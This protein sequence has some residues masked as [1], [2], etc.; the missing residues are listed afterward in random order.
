MFDSAFSFL[1]LTVSS[2]T[3]PD[4]K[5][6][7]RFLQIVVAARLLL[8]APVSSLLFFVVL[9]APGFESAVRPREDHGLDT[10]WCSSHVE[11]D[12]AIAAGSF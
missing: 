7:V 12:A 3:Y 8:I 11:N 1:I 2:H 10:R 5:N 4:K 9:P 6:F